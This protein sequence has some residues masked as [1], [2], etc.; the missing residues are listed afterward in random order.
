MAEFLKLS[1]ADWNE[2]FRDP[3]TESWQDRWT[4]DGLKA[5]VVNSEKGRGFK[6][7]PVRK[8]NASHAV[9]WTKKSFAGDIRPDYEYTM[10]TS[11]R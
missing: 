10:T 2:V 5:T 8:E 3:C 9:M 1:R 11:T 6:A 7:G 4:L